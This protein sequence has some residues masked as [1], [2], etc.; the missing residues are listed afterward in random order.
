[1]APNAISK[2]N[3]HVGGQQVI[4]NLWKKSSQASQSFWY[5]SV[6]LCGGHSC[7]GGRITRTSMLHSGSVR[8]PSDGAVSIDTGRHRKKEAKRPHTSAV[9]NGLVVPLLL[10]LL[11]FSRV[12]DSTG[13][14][15]I[16]KRCNKRCCGLYKPLWPRI[17]YCAP[18]VYFSTT[19][20]QQ[21][22]SFSLRGKCQQTSRHSYTQQHPQKTAF[23]I[24]CQSICW[25]KE[26]SSKLNR[27]HRRSAVPE[28][29]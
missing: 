8:N 9:R 16:Y 18:A 17:W 20:E 24:Y 27:L 15:W 13:R 10:L 29:G 23:F 3:R 25:R 14:S 11:L 2:Y 4:G 19:K 12:T 28:S 26:E 7:G 21:L 6:A 1:M 5:A 22:S